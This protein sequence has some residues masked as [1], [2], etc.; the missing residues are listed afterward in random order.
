MVS[1]SSLFIF[2]RAKSAAGSS[3]SDKYDARWQTYHLSARFK[4]TDNEPWTTRALCSTLCYVNP[5]V[6]LAIITPEDEIDKLRQAR[7]LDG[8]FCEKCVKVAIVLRDIP[9]E[10]KEQEEK[11]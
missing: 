7:K 2:F 8:I 3:I 6:D 1:S 10:E 11:E 9:L 4:P 5:A